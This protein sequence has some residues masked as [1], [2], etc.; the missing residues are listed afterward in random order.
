MKNIII[1][2][3]MIVF[4]LFLSA[5][6]T[7]KL[8]DRQKTR[9]LFEEQSEIESLVKEISRL[10]RSKSITD[11]TRNTYH[12]TIFPADTFKFS[13]QKGFIGMA[14]KIVLEGTIEQLTKVLDTA[15][16]TNSISSESTGKMRRDLNARTADRTSLAETRGNI[17]KGVCVGLITAVVILGIWRKF[18]GHSYR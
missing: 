7:G 16:F 6:R 10:N 11:S 14:S 17:W 12:L 4:V 2:A 1:L 13:M 3:G 8:S 9:L 15:T 18:N 5:C